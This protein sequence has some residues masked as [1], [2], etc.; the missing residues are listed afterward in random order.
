[1]TPTTPITPTIKGMVVHA[2]GAAGEMKW[3][4]VAL[5]D[6]EADEIQ[7]RHTAVGL[8]FIDVYFRTGVYA[9][10]QLPFTPGLEGAGVVEKVGAGVSDFS[11]GE[12]VAYASPPLGAYCEARNLPAARA[13]KIPDGIDDRSAAAIMLKGMT[14]HYLLRSAYRVKAGETILFHAAAGGV[15]LLA[16]QWAKHLG[17]TV[18]G[19]AGSEEKTALARANGCQHAIN[20]NRENFVEGVQEITGG[21]GVS[22]VYDSVGQA[23]FTPSLDCLKTRGTMVSFG[24]SSGKVAPLDIGILNT[25]GGLYLTR[26][27]LFHY[28]AGRDELIYRAGEVFD[29]VRSGA[30]SIRINQTYP[31]SEAVTAHKDL[32][33]RRTTGTTVL[34]P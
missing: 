12:R 7:V 23:T 4:Q 2:T 24:Q 5:T 19:T 10:P 14:A 15:G 25:K 6:P 21:T 34:I 28:T 18:I 1:M 32:E 17:V 30:L 9:A 33:N 20:Y 29:A 16:C 8:N 3:E 11:V 31:L 27:S 26:P 22:V 13:V